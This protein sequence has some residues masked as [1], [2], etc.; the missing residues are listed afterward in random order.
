[1]RIVLKYATKNAMVPV[2]AV[3]AVQ[4]SVLVAASFVIERIFAIPGLGTLLIDSVVRADYP[5]LQGSIVVV[6]LIVLGVNL[7]VDILYGIVNP[8][9]RPQ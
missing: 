3:L 4:M 7:A 9:V 5:V 6:A 2:L 1:R 8:K